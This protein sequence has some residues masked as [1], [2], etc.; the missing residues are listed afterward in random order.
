[1]NADRLCDLDLK[2]VSEAIQ[3]REVSSVEA[4]EAYL[5]R[6]ERYDSVLRS[7]LTVTAEP[8]L[9]Q[10]RAADAELARGHS[11]GPLHGV[12]LGLKDLIA[13]R[14]VRMTGGSRLLAD[15]VPTESSPVVER[16]LGAGAVLLGK[17][18]MS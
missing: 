12:P 7:Y 9:E 17:Q 6:I 15:Y 5:Q 1:V 11:R 10:A 4:T 16:L 18:A 8:A 13:W 2:V 14:G 3:G